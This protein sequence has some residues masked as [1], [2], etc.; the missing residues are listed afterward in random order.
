MNN[1]TPLTESD[2][3]RLTVERDRLVSE[4]SAFKRFDQKR[5]NETARELIRVRYLL[6]ETPLRDLTES[7][8]IESDPL[9]YSA[10]RHG[11]GVRVVG[12]RSGRRGVIESVRETGK[13]CSFLD[14]YVRWDDGELSVQ[15]EPLRLE[16]V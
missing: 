15:N 3:L 7:A 16:E 12:V 9:E 4:L 1:S 8:R 10:T 14:A 11:C 5:F 2:R 6:G 13:R